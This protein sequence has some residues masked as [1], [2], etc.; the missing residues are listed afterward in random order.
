[1]IQFQKLC[2]KHAVW[3]L[4]ILSLGLLSMTDGHGRRFEDTS[5]WAARQQQI[6]FS[7]IM[8]NISRP[9]AAPG[10]VVAAPSHSNPDYYF[11]WVRDAALTMDTVVGIYQTTQSKPLKNQLAHVLMDYISF[12]RINQISKTLTGLGEP[13]FNVDGTPYNLPW[14]RPQ[15]DGPALRAITATHLAFLLLREGQ[16]DYVHRVLYDGTLPTSSLIKTDLE[17]VSHH[18]R[19]TS[20]D[21]WEEVRA[22]HFYTRMVQRRALVEGAQ[23][24]RVL[25]DMGAAEFYTL[26]A[27]LISQDLGRFFRSDS[28]SIIASLDWA[29]GVNYKNSNLDVAILLGV[30]HGD[31]GDGFLNASSPWVLSTTQRLISSF[32]QLYNVN[33]ALN[34]P[35]VAIGRYPEDQYSGSGFSGGNPWLLATAAVGEI[36]FKA[37]AELKCSNPQSAAQYRALGEQFLQRIQYH[38]NPD[39]SMYEQWDRNTGYATSAPDLTW[40]YA[41][42]LT[43]MNARAAASR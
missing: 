4:S 13:K 42:F 23:L 20:F 22:S 15:N 34:A 11:H 16:A 36:Y 27:K 38:A 10:S 7:K 6:A 17:Y 41:S 21:L 40:S 39:G 33:R 14:G 24:A 26:Q 19:D 9:D 12:S 32:S 3:L 31:A 28:Q 1:M 2:Q 5:T 35:G 30:L 43:L 18:W 25:G 8:G 29:E 37:A